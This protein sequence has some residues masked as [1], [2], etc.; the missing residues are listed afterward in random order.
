MKKG[1]SQ[2]KARIKA[3]T[4]VEILIAMAIA[5]LVGAMAAGFTLMS[6]KSALRITNQSELNGSA[7]NMV[8][9]LVKRVRSARMSTVS[10]DGYTLTLVYDDYG[11]Q[12]TDGDGNFFNDSDHIEVFQ[13]SDGDGTVTTVED[14]TITYR[15][16]GK[17][18]FSKVALTD[19]Q[20]IGNT[21]IFKINAGNHRQ[22]DV[23]FETS[24]ITN[25]GQRQRIEMI[26][27]AFRLN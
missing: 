14:N 16:T 17:T 15:R 4:L 5:V 1:R 22:I 10:K 8:S 20:Q 9:L 24:K 27:S 3:F 23:T 7:S 26:T 21:P 13:F 12:D 18:P 25:H 2:S 11:Y 6:S 19:V